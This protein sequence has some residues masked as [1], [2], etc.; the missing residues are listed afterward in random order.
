NDEMMDLDLGAN[1]LQ[2]FPILTSL[3]PASGGG[4][5]FLVTLHSLRDYQFQ[6]DFY[7]NSECDPSGHGE[8]REHLFSLNN[9]QT[10]TDAQGNL[11]FRLDL[12]PQEALL[13]ATATDHLGDT[14]EFSPCAGAVIVAVSTDPPFRAAP[15]EIIRYT[16]EA[17]TNQPSLIP[18]EG[19]TVKFPV[20]KYTDFPLKTV[21][22]DTGRVKATTREIEWSLP[23]LGRD[24]TAVLTF[25]FA[26]S[27]DVVELHTNQ[28]YPQEFV[29]KGS[30]TIGSLDLPIEHRL[31]L[32]QPDLVI[33]GLE[34]AQTIQN[35]DNDVRPLQ[36]KP[37]M[38]RAFIQASYPDAREGCDVPKIPGPG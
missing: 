34:V 22:S 16:V 6:L 28:N 7:D 1:D 30:V 32:L 10:R 21:H 38:A 31:E 19:F 14:S 25:V 36:Q 27:C 8:G 33:T 5:A 29:L 35:L 23:R 20:P 3:A 17:S 2:N 18:P 13:T 15:G 37:L 11:S 12:D 9:E 26:V 4:A 24:E